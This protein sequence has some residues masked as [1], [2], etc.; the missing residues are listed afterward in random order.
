[1]VVDDCGITLISYK[2]I[3]R[4]INSE[5]TANKCQLCALTRTL[6]L[7]SILYFTRC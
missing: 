7:L 2:I 5:A 6:L 1:M 3:K 4:T